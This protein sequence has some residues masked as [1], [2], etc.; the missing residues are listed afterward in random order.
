M[1]D[2]KDWLIEHEEQFA[3]DTFGKEYNELDEDELIQ[4]VAIM[5]EKYKDY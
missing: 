5:E 2:Y 1:L 3:E 4:L